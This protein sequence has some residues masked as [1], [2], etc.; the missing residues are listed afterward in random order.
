MGAVLQRIG[1]VTCTRRVE[2]LLTVVGGSEGCGFP[3]S[4][5]IVAAA[6]RCCDRVVPHMYARGQ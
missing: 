2:T 5:V 6:R 4:R 1:V 3:S